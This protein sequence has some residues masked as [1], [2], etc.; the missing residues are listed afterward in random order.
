MSY[1]PAR[2]NEHFLNPRNVGETVEADAAGE[3]GSL[4]CGAILL[5]TLNIDAQS[6]R[7]T[8]AKFK[9]VGC[10]YLIA[11]A[12]VW[13]ETIKDLSLARAATLSETAVTDWLGPMPSGRAHCATLCREAL[14]AAL[15]NYHSTTREEWAGDEALICT[16][17]GVSEKTIERVI[18]AR[19]LRTVAEVTRACHAGGGCQ[20]CHPLIVDILE[21]YWRTLEAGS[22]STGTP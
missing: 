20:S 22:F 4:A 10:G 19:A 11:S 6:Q 8:D 7:I 5:L 9:A 15:V 14:N 21:D 16:C 12:S 1:Y 3:S 2:V 18:E 17:F 13:T